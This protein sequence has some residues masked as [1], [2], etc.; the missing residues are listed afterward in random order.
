MLRHTLVEQLRFTSASYPDRP[1][2]QVVGGQELTYAAALDRTL[3]LATAI[4]ERGDGSPVAI[5]LRNG[6][7][8]VLALLACQLAG[9]P[10]L[11]VNGALTASEVDYVLADS[12]A[13]L[14][15]HGPEFVDLVAALARRRVTVS[16]ADL[17]AAQP[18]DAFQPS[19]PGDPFVI[20]YTSG[21]TG[22]PKGAIYDG[23]GMYVQYLRWAVHFG[24]TA[25]STLLTAGPMFHNSYGGLSILALALGATNR[26]LTAF[27]PATACAELEQR[28][29]FAFLVP[30]MLTQVLERW[31][32]TGTAMTSLRCL[33]SSGAAVDPAQLDAAFDAF[34]AAAITEAYGWSEGGWVTHETKRRGAVVPQSVGHPMVGADVA[35]F[36]ADGVRCGPGETG[37]IGVCN[38]TPFLGYVN[39]ASTAETSAD[40]RYLLS[41]DVGRFTEDGRLLVVDRKKDIIVTGGENVA[42]GEVERVLTAHPAVREV[43]VVGR[44]DARWG[45]AVTAV[46][47][48]ESEVDAAVL[49]AH[50]RERLAAYKVP[51]E[52]EFVAALPRNSMGKV[53]KFLLR[54]PAR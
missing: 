26:V 3:A 14:L 40:G 31:R 25:E 48:T 44:R 15:L 54:E 5:L 42:S 23:A 13:G 24:L 39:P 52:I 8:A 10:A 53:Q 41:G 4:R 34:P 20:G 16:T 32:A 17:P 43:A 30:S 6:P 47:V 19:A 27:H 35:L 50:C 51:K 46:V 45:E 22:F 49:R 2:V 29:T 12:S 11:P 28:C 38:V 37:E 36:D 1:A 9:V 7:D 21:T 33:L 18:W